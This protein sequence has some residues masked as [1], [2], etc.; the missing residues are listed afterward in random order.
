MNG[1][2][3]TNVKTAA[4][5]LKNSSNAGCAKIDR[6]IVVALLNGLANS[7]FG[8]EVPVKVVLWK[9]FDDEKFM[10]MKTITP[11]PP[12]VPSAIAGSLPSI[13]IAY[14]T[15]GVPRG[16]VAFSVLYNDKPVYAS[17]KAAAAKPKPK[18][19]SPGYWKRDG[20]CTA[21]ELVGKKSAANWGQKKTTGN[22]AKPKRCSPGFWRRGGDCVAKGLVGKKSAADWGKKKKPVNGGTAKKQQLNAT[23]AQKRNTAKQSSSSS[24]SSNNNNAARR[25]PVARPVA[26][27]NIFKE[28]G[29]S[30]NNNNAA[31]RQ[32]AAKPA[33][34]KKLVAKPAAKKKLL[35]KLKISVP[36]QKTRNE[37]EYER[38][39]KKINNK[40]PM[41]QSPPY[42]TTLAANILDENALAAA[43]AFA[44]GRNAHINAAAKQYRRN[45]AL[46]KKQRSNAMHKLKVNLQKKKLARKQPGLD[47][48]LAAAN[49]A[50]RKRDKNTLA[51]KKNAYVKAGGNPEEW[52]TYYNY[53]G[54]PPRMPAPA[55][56]PRAAAKNT[57][58][59]ALK[60]LP[61][62]APKAPA[63]K[64]A[65]KAPAPNVIM[66]NNANANKLAAQ[67]GL[68]RRRSNSNYNSNEAR[69]E[70]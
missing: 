60:G 62:A 22:A 47:K 67:L 31:R 33:A 37:L 43:E 10:R 39:L 7:K 21:K 59:Q 41:P 45:V 46:V 50:A 51:Q 19:C 63:P 42:R 35:K 6:K 44:A 24:S 14:T 68:R 2:N 58:T 61:K 20:V 34:K 36:R 30:S 32:P 64:P 55:P 56:K 9:R 54:I 52:N 4:G 12:A 66:M 26:H 17:N 23:A 57:L 15:R 8:Q 27:H 5:L 65:P 70:I 69:R 49:E 29:L 48:K 40:F 11:A 38:R 16:T 18:K 53:Y 25:Q 3:K 1:K 13:N 28:L